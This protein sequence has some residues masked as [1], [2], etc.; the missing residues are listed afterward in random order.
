M[1]ISLAPGDALI[2]VVVQDDFLPGGS[3]AVPR[4]DEVIPVLNCNPDLFH[5]RH[6]PV[7]TTRDWHT[8]DHCSFIAQGGPWPPH[9]V[10]DTPGTRRPRT[11]CRGLYHLQGHRCLDGAR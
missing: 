6:L 9:C 7:F 11:A 1:E 3:L 5:S 8:P 4:G 2:V 10:A